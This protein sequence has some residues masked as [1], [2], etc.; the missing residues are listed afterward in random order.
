MFSSLQR[1][2]PRSLR[3]KKGHGDRYNITVIAEYGCAFGRLA[4]P[5]GRASG[6]AARW[7]AR[8]SAERDPLL[9]LPPPPPPPP[10]R[11]ARPARLADAW[12]R[13]ASRRRARGVRA[14]DPAPLLDALFI[15][16]RGA[17]SALPSARGAPRRR[18]LLGVPPSPRARRAPVDAGELGGA[19]APPF[20]LASRRARPS[21]A[22]RRARARGRPLASRAR[23]T[24]IAPRRASPCG[25][26]HERGEGRARV[27]GPGPSLAGPGR[28]RLAGERGEVAVG[29]GSGRGGERAAGR[30]SVPEMRGRWGA[31]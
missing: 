16:R 6:R 20:A 18:P 26:G 31:G 30:W 1:S 8:V 14:R 21:A 12:A 15:A 28:G 3:G 17:G 23:S 2:L 7:A 22:G 13:P 24:R 29:G 10:P 4:V 11:W 19:R 27:A 9:L 5:F 25:E